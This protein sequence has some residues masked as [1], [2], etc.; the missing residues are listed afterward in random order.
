MTYPQCPIDKDIC[1]DL[2]KEILT[3]YGISY[4][5]VSSEQHEDGSPHLHA[6][7][8]LTSKY[9]QRNA[10]CLDIT[11]PATDTVYHGNYQASRNI[12]ASKQY[13]KK[14]GNFT[15]EGNDATVAKRTRDEAFAEALA[16]N[17]RQEAEE[18]L[19]SKAPRDYCMGFGNITSCL[20]KVFKPD[21]APY[22][23]D[24]TIDDFTLPSGFWSWYSANFMVS[25]LRGGLR[26]PGG[27]SRPQSV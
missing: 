8:S 20:D 5:V 21:P 3:T 4:I 1:L 11:D 16:A 12:A 27:A 25:S 23:S 6:F 24:W 2:L 9:D 26:R 22:Q 13:V 17:T 10:N 7:I 18:I 14:D 19:R 15:E